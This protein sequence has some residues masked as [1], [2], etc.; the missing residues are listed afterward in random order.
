[1]SVDGPK[2]YVLDEVQITLWEA[3]IFGGKGA[4]IV[5]YR[6]CLQ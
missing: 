3:A 1:V 2:E 5:K 6:D 4:L